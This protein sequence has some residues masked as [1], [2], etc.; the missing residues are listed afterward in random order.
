MYHYTGRS[1]T[2][3][4]IIF[5]QTLPDPTNTMLNTSQKLHSIISGTSPA[6]AIPS[7]SSP[8]KSSFMVTVLAVSVVHPPNSR[9]LTCTSS[10]QHITPIMIDLH[11]P[12]LTRPSSS[13]VQQASQEQLGR[14]NTR[15]QKHT[16]HIPY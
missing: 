6:S 3:L 5:D 13:V 8:P 1:P 9:L 11:W 2:H 12:W 15:D 16:S 4:G 7:L 10:R 14:R